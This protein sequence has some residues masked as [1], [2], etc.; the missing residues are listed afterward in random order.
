MRNPHC[1]LAFLGVENGLT[2]NGGVEL[3]SFDGARTTSESL[4]GDKNFSA[5]SC[6]AMRWSPDGRFLGVLRK[7][8]CLEVIEIES[9]ERTQIAAQIQGNEKQLIYSTLKN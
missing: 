9:G 7:A 6:E 2:K 4:V 8:G 1:N 3:R 5:D